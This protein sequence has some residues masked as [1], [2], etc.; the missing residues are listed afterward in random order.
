MPIIY[1]YDAINLGNATHFGHV[2]YRKAVFNNKRVVLK[3]NKSSNSELSRFEVAFTGLAQRFLK[4][5]LT[6]EQALVARDGNIIGL[7]SQHMFYEVEAMEGPGQR[8]YKL[9]KDDHVVK[10]AP[11]QVATAED[12][13]VNFFD[14]FPSNFFAK[15]C[16]S[17]KKGELTLDM[18]SLA[19]VLTSSY[20]LEEDDLH[21]GNLGFYLVQKNGKP[22]VVF[23]KIDHDLMM[24]DSIMSYFNP[25]FVNL[26]HGEHAFEVTARD[27]Q[28]FPRLFDSENHYWPTTRRY[29]IKPSD[30]RVYAGSEEIEA[31]MNIGQRPDFQQAKWRH[32]Y[33]HIMMPCELIESS[34]TAS[35]DQE[36][37][38]DAAQI[39][40]IAHSVIARQA[41]LRAVLFSMPEFREFIKNMRSAEHQALVNE[42]FHNVDVSTRISLEGP[43][44]QTI[45]TQKTLCMNGAFVRG[46]SP[47]HAAI[48]LGDFR[49][50][51]TWKSFGQFGDTANSEGKRPLDIALEMAHVTDNKNAN[52]DTRHNFLL[53]ARHLLAEKV[54]ET[55][56]Y[57][58]LDCAVKKNIADGA[59]LSIHLDKA[60]VASS[61]RELIEAIRGI[62]EDHRYSLKMKKNLSIRCIKA[63]ITA[64]KKSPEFENI[65]SEFKLALNG[66]DAVRPAPELQ[67]IR[68]LRSRFWIVRLI[69]G[70]L[71]GTATQVTINGLLDNELKQFAPARSSCGFSFFSTGKRAREQSTMDA[72]NNRAN[73]ATAEPGSL[74]P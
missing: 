11:K 25:R 23:L 17:E 54:G 57:K 59:F 20:T 26:R 27:L 1:P 45:T 33:K 35:F 29:F 58:N 43:L 14:Q 32:F 73:D 49:Y 4:P 16:D 69:R 15:L 71:G 64:Q 47:M 30:R 41:R 55:A 39:A 2:V 62:G 18:D 22:H 66:N 28:H 3:L 52:D 56:T 61:S 12:I 7:A 21:K 46:D 10:F 5:G 53:V 31:F 24:S 72:E 38:A 37:P 60:V 42:I 70:L 34:L 8:F 6:S 63:F 50:H 19:S 74:A 44:I 48:R 13:P 51:E 65:I 40:M 9:K 67:F 68:Q 36:I